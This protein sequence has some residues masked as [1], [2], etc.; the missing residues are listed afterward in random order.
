MGLR[1]LVEFLDF[2]GVLLGWSALGKG[3]GGVD[4]VQVGAGSKKDSHDLQHNSS[5][6]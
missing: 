6:A 5:A 1:D 3:G 2:A 4:G